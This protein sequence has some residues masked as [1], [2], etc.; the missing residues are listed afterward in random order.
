MICPS[1]EK[2]VSDSASFCSCCGTR[3]LS[4]DAVIKKAPVVAASKSSRIEAKAPSFQPTNQTDN[5]NVTI[6]YR[7]RWMLVFIYWIGGFFGLHDR[8]LGYPANLS[9]G[10]LNYLG[11]FFAIFTPGGWMKFIVFI[12]KYVAGY[13]TIIGGKSYSMDAFGNPVVY[14]KPHKQ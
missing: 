1:C 12:F 8:W 4:T 7:S 14:F 3:L 11:N 6:K 10:I 5:N 9:N 2:T 13:F